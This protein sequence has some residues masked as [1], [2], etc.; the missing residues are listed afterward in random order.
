M[1]NPAKEL[2]AGDKVL[3]DA[4]VVRVKGDEVVVRLDIITT[5]KDL[6]KFDDLSS[7]TSILD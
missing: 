6:M 3:L 1:S 4:T 2:K 7:T 5:K